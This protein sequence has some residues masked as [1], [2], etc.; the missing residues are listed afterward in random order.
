MRLN[1][2]LMEKLA[3]P[4]EYTA[5]RDL[6]ESGAIRITEE[7]RGMIRCSVADQGTCSVTLTRRL[8]IH[9]DC[10]TFLHKGCC[11]HGCCRRKQDRN[12]GSACVQEKRNYM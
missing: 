5:G 2:L 4:E 3:G 1:P 11:R 9:C 8:V 7:D 10:D 12:S 6:E